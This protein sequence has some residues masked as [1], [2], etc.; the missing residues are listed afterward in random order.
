MTT[1][2]RAYCW[3]DNHNGALGDNT[4]TDRLTPA[5][6]AGTRLFDNVN[7][8]GSYTCGVTLGGKGF[9]WGNNGLGQLGTG[10]NISARPDAG[11][12]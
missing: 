8:V 12:R 3:G 7:T 9:C 4:R 11:G 2:N 10:S 1:A 6:V 5:P